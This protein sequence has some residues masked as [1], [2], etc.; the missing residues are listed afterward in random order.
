M[1]F[2]RHLGQFSCLLLTC[3][4]DRVR[5]LG[6]CLRSPAALAAENLFRRTQLALYRERQ[7]KPWRAT[8]ATGV[9]LAW[10]AR[11]FDWRQAVIIVQP[12]TLI[13][14]HH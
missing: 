12:A 4:V 5:Y 13:R 2:M 6:F 11:W 3:F 14:W 10:L 9:T 1:R 7:V 8:H